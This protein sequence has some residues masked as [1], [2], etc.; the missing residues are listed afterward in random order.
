MSRSHDYQFRHLS[1]FWISLSLISFILVNS[2]QV[3]VMSQSPYTLYYIFI[4]MHFCEGTLECNK[5]GIGKL[6]H[7]GSHIKMR[8]PAIVPKAISIFIYSIPKVQLRKVQKPS[9]Q[10]LT[11]HQVFLYLLPYLLITILWKGKMK[12]S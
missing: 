8:S 5:S 9:Y 1:F 12:R 11:L 4:L 7:T 3:P 2:V 10:L 6:R